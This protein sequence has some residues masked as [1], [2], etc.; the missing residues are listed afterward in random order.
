MLF[1]GDCC[2]MLRCDQS[3]APAIDRTN[4]PIT[5]APTF[6][7]SCSQ[8]RYRARSGRSGARAAPLAGQSSSAGRKKIARGVA[9][10]FPIV[11]VK[12]EPAGV[13]LGVA[14]EH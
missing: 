11:L 4:T 12:S 9:S 5:A 10:D 1:E 2:K 13:R 8:E 7:F 14:R 6:R 3:C